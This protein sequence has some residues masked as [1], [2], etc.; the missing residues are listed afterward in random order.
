MKLRKLEMKDAPLMLEWMHDKS[1]VENMQADF[2]SFTIENCENF[3]A[4]SQDDKECC[5][6]I[7]L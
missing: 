3:I 4:N 1:V 5:A 2:A 6:I 7:K